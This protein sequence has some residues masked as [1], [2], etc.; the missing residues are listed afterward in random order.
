MST[1]YKQA[2]PLFRQPYG[3]GESRII[4]G[5][6]AAKGQFPHQAAMSMD[7]DDSCGG[8]LISKKWILTTG[9]CVRG[10]AKWTVVLGAHNIRDTSEP[11]RVTLTSTTAIIHENFGIVTLNNDVALVQLPQDVQLSGMSFFYLYRVGYLYA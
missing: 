5:K 2:V 7:N 1:A 3:S 9:S 4:G 10:F 8:S 6:E 11:G